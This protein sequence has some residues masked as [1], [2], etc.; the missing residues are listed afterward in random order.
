MTGIY[1][2]TTRRTPTG[3]TICPHEAVTVLQAV[4]AYTMGGAYASFEEG[5]KGSIEPGKLADLVVL[6]E[7]I[8]KIT[9]EK[10]LKTKVEMTMV[11]GRV[12]YERK[13]A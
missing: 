13:D 1:F 9:P 4:R 2:A 3:Q 7:N 6:S 11:D 12:V 5:I 8:L 10:I